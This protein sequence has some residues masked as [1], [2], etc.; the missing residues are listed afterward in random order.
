MRPLLERHGDRVISVLS[1][2]LLLV[3]WE[4]LARFHIINPLFFPTPSS[5]AAK[6]MQLAGTGELWVN[7][8]VSL[9][10]LFWGFVIGGIPALVLGIVMGLSRPVRLFVNPLVASTYPIPK[11]ALLPL[12]LLIFGLDENSKIAMVAMGV[13][14]P[15]L[16]NSVT[17]VLQIPRIYFDVGKNFGASR[18]KIFL[19]IALPGAAPF[20]FTGIKLGV[21][22]GLILISIAE[23]VGASSGLGYMIWNAWQLMDVE[24]MYVGLFII[25]FLGFVFSLFLDEAERWL[26]PW[27][28]A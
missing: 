24:T 6:F 1:P 15:V 4:I 28:P 11:S 16:M 19:T 8:G 9:R 3:V 27:R 12:V 13:F 5:I 22:M 26:L 25:A 23:M 18:W 2:I 21:G 10:R 14:Y 7:I 20:I 17:G